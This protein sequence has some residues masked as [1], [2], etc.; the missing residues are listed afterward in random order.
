MN[1]GYLYPQIFIKLNPK[2]LKDKSITSILEYSFIL[3]NENKISK[4]KIEKSEDIKDILSKGLNNIYFKIIYEPAFNLFLDLEKAVITR[5]I[6]VYLPWR[7]EYI[8]VEKGTKVDLIEFSGK[9]IHLFVREGDTI[10]YND[11]IAYILTGKLEVR[12]YRSPSKGVLLYI[13]PLSE[14]PVKYL[15]VVVNESKTRRYKE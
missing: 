7:K 15:L 9:N 11:K 6:I 13:T 5:D 14:K 1:N 8:K 3:E 12:T 2:E 10:E 4:F